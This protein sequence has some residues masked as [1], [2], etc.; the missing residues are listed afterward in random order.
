MRAADPVSEARDLKG[1]DIA[2][3]TLE[4]KETR[5]RWSLFDLLR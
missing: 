5:S 3:A 1:F 4:K 2:L